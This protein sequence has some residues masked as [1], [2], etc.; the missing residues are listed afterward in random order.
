MKNLQNYSNFKKISPNIINF[1]RGGVKYNLVMVFICLNIFTNLQSQTCN[2]LGVVVSYSFN[3]SSI[4]C[5]YAM[6]VCINTIGEGSYAFV[7]P[8][9]NTN[10][11]ISDP[12]DFKNDCFLDDY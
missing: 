2:I 12:E 9:S 11:T 7:I 6:E 8:K 3:G 10:V 5:T 4:G 1:M